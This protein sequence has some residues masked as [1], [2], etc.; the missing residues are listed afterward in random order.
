MFHFFETAWDNLGTY[1]FALLPLTV[2]LLI[3]LALSF[4]FLNGLHDAANSI[5]TVVSTRVLS[6]GLAIIWAAFFN[7]V[8]FVVFPLKVAGTIQADVISQEVIDNQFLAATLIGACAWNVLTWYLGLP[9][10]SSHALIGG[11]VGAALVTTGNFSALEGGFFWI[12]LFIFLAPA[13]GF[14]LGTAIA[15]AVA[16][17]CRRTPPRRVDRIF[18]WG[19]FFSAGFFSLG[20]GGNDAQ[21]TMGIIFLLLIKAGG[22]GSQ[23][24]YVPTEVVLACHMAMGL[25]TLFG[26]WRIVK[27]MGQ[28]IIRLRP[29]DGFCAESGAALTLA[30][31]TFIR[32]IPI[33]T[34]HT[35]TGA[36]IGVGSLRR[37][38]AVRWGVAGQV[39]WAWI[40]TIPGSALLA[41][42][43]LMPL[44]WMLR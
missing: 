36:I 9:T 37:F 43:T 21:K 38:S 22:F 8:A 34:T 31:T 16:W 19:Q 6:P 27:T 1:P 32:G 3:A 15:V 13:I 24:P 33:S 17:L 41:G 42:V 30:A 28:G 35:I 25:G 11:M 5:A 44:R 7:F 10:S 14:V 39:V 4:D 18:R 26:G 23:R 29:V 2:W 20:H 40:L 12:V